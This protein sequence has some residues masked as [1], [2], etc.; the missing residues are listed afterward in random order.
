M[1]TG[2]MKPIRVG[3]VADPAAPTA[4]ARTMVDLAPLEGR[5]WDIT[6]VS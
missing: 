1:T 5:G 3:L 4:I 2:R 6:V